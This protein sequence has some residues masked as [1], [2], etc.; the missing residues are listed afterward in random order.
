M[1]DRIGETA[2][3]LDR[4]YADGCDEWN[5]GLYHGWRLG[6]AGRLLAMALYA[7]VVAPVLIAGL[8]RRARGKGRAPSRSEAV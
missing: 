6:D 1:R 7:V 3:A 5:D 4:L 8:I 2:S